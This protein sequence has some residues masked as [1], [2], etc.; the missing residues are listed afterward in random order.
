MESIPL[1]AFISWQW[2]LL[3]IAT[4]PVPYLQLTAINMI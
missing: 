3:F 2:L 4:L 1:E